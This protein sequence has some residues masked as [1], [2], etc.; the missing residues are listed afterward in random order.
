MTTNNKALI[1]FLLAIISFVTKTSGQYIRFDHFD[2]RKGLSQNN[3]NSLTV[4]STGYVWMG[5]IEGITRFDGTN[6]DI[7]RS[8]PFQANTLEGNF[9]EKVSSCPNGNIWVHI[10]DR[11]LNLYNA[12]HDNFK[13]IQDSCFYPADVVHTTSLVSALDSLLW[14]TDP[15]GLYTYNL[16]K[17]EANKLPSPPG[18]NYVIYAG[19]N[20]VLLWGSGGISLYSLTEKEK[21]PKLILEQ[22]VQDISQVFNDSLVVINTGVLEIL[23]IKT[24]ERKQIPRNE[25]LNRYLKNSGIWSL[26]GYNN[27]IWIGLTTCLVQIIMDGDT[28]DRV[29]KYSYDPFSE[30]SFHGQDAKNFAFDKAGN[31][32]IGTSKY[33]VNY[34]SRGKNLFSH[35]PISILSK[36]DQEIDP[37]RALCQSSDGNIWVGFDRLGLVCIQPDNTQILYSDIYFPGNA[38][39]SLE[40]IRSIYEDSNGKLWIG[41]NKGLCNYNPANN[42]VESTLVKYGWEWPDVCYRMH[43]FTRG[44][45]TVTNLDGIGIVDLNKGTLD[46]I[47]MPQNYVAGSIRS[48]AKD[49]KSNYWFVSGDLGMCKFTPEGELTYYTYEKDHFS[50]SKLYSLEIVG[51]T[52]WIGSN[53][54]LMAFDLIEEKVVS[55]FFESDGLSNNLIYSTICQNNAIWMSTNRGISRLNLKNFSI[56]KYLTDDL[57]MDDAF[58]QSRDGRIYFG[59]YNGFISFEPDKINVKNVPPNPIITDLFINNH[60]VKVGEK[61]QN[62]VLLSSSIKNSK[63]LKLNYSTSYFSLAFDAFPFNYPDQTTFRYRISGQ[64]PEWIIAPPKSNRAVISNLSPGDYIFEV[65]ASENAR[66]WSAPKQLQL[67]IVPPFYST[68]W[69]R[70]MGILFILII[71][72]LILRI[73]IYTIKRWNIQL[74]KQIKEQTF[75]IEEQKNKIIAQKEKM[76]KLNQR[77][78][79]AD[80]AKLRY[81][82][83]LSHEFR[84]PLTII[85]GNI[86]LLKDHGVNKFILKNIRRSSD[87][88]FRL[89]NQFIDLHKYDHGELKLQVSH[90]DIVSFTKEIADTFKD[91]AQRKNINIKTLNPNETITLWLDKDKTDKIIYNIVANAIKYTNEGGSVFIVFERQENGVELKITDTGVG[92]SEEEQKNIFNRF[93][94]SE[95]IDTYTDGHGMGL[96]LVKALVETQKGTI[97]CSS[98]EDV[99]TTFKVFFKEGKQHFKLSDIVDEE[100]LLNIK[101]VEKPDITVIDPGN[102]SGDE[103]LLVEDNPEL[104]EYL[105]ALLGKYYKIQTAKNGKEA[106]E[107]LKEST[108]E[109]IITDLMMPVMDGLELSKTIREIPETRFIPIIMLSAKTDV[110]SKIEG[111]QTNI[112]D[113]IEKPFNANL[114]LSRINNILKK[115]QNIRKDV[116]Q[117]S[118]SKSDSWSDEDKLFYKKILIILDNNYSDPEFNADTFSNSIGMS[119][120]T[121]YRRMKKLNQENPGEFIRKYRLK[122]AS[123]LLKEGGKPINEICTEVGFQSLSN[124]RKSFKEEYGVIPSKYKISM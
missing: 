120:V 76:V 110:S 29:S 26:A 82:T 70:A 43:E 92:I 28:I 3:I 91:Y 78:R 115:Y 45:M 53:T 34:Y 31:L 122:K 36:A 121:F 104:L 23:N 101:P 54:G 41:T 17:N 85:M 2:T 71:F 73:R 69:F 44:K 103:I 83:N 75:S 19:H 47:N 46:K 13:I 22:A 94:R 59:G 97:S 7:F 8:L 119:R 27:E 48:I 35:H 96:T 32:W 116:E 68:Y 40:N 84:T 77:L 89:V 117:F 11:G 55:S 9:I 106:L 107:R 65:E 57:F 5:T 39:K 51:D 1:F 114:L 67:T 66:D 118:A 74:E 38:I 98:Q 33:G 60:K 81:Y 42:H 25:E 50:D 111:Y 102:P 58:Y 4:D 21:A 61:I 10:Q 30:Y 112:D 52:M 49:K 100:L 37:I 86:D 99:G 80:Q 93:F 12:T 123:N 14:L 79:E 56:E 108:P 20:K 109:L 62:R 64:S 24:G 113:Y 90:F 63:S 87:R 88:L 6:F 124:F 16:P 105:S 95:K 72:Y 15:N 18:R